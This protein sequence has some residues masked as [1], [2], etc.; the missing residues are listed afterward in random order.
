V[1][2]VPDSALLVLGP[3]AGGIR[4][5]V[6]VLRDGLRDL[7]WQVAT[8]GPAGVLDGL[9][10]VDHAVDVGSSP[11]QVAVAARA[12]RRL[13]GEADVVHA[14]GLKAGLCTAV[15]GVHPRLM[16]VHNV[17]LDDTAGRMAPVLRAIERRLPA[18]MDRTIAVSADIASTFAGSRGEERVVVVA[19]AG[20]LPVPARDGATVRR[21]LGVGDAP[22][23]TTVARLHPQKDVPTLLAAARR[24]LDQRPEV[25]FVV[26]GGG[27]SEAEVR[28]E[29]QRLDLG[30]SVQLLGARPSAA[31]EL[32]AADVVA[33]SSVWEGS[34]LVVAESLLLGRP[35]AVTAVGAVPE[36]VE[37]GVTGR[38]V[39][40]RDPA[41]LADAIL[42]LL[43]DPDEAERLAAA[44]QALARE[45]FAP[46]VLVREVERHYREV[47]R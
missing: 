10:G 11:R 9:G 29:H 25:R 36:V 33:L 47:L 14:H 7:G 31:D 40:P 18:R 20:P 38:L 24:V 34:P 13:A 42:D 21:D 27:P 1:V 28:A 15:A 41:A 37:D 19:P 4:R 12:I 5:H 35:V 22:L 16:T 30:E 17:V 39:E 44:G 26:V 32:A 46:E 43:A 3:S 45:R 23:V 6:A 8:A 2:V